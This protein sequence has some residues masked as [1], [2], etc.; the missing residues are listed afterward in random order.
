MTPVVES[1]IDDLLPASMGPD[2]V[3]TEVPAAIGVVD[4]L[5]VTFASEAI[6]ERN[7]L[8]LGPICSA[9]RV[10]V[11]DG[12][13]CS[14]WS[15]VETIARRVG[16]TSPALTRSTLRPLADIELIELSDGRVRSTGAWYPL[17]ARLTAVELK[18]DRWQRALRQ[19]D[20]FALSTDSAWVILDHQRTAAADGHRDLFKEVGVGLAA[21][22]ADGTLSILV[23]PRKRQP[24]G[25]LRALIAERAWRAATEQQQLDHTSA[26]HVSRK[27]A[28][29]R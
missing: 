8:G 7:R 22:D 10:R 11:L 28:P 26:R 2:M 17:A 4:L 6:A 13:S 12:L 21:V 14:R 16:S 25:W 29:T 20:N 18:L 3:L 9:L 19:A 23:R 1:C 5:A 15:R 24:V 27:P